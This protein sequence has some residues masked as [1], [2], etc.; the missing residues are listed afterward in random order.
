[1]RR[2]AIVG[3][4]V[5]GALACAR[6]QEKAPPPAT[7][8][9]AAAT[10][11]PGGQAA[12]KPSPATA[13]SPAPGQ[14]ELAGQWEGRYDAKKATITLPAK[15]KE[16]GTDDG[17]SAVGAGTV[18]LAVLA[19]GDVRGKLSGALGAGTITGKLDGAM[20]RASVQP[21]DPYAARAMSG[22]F[23]GEQKGDV[24][25]CE[26]HVAGPDGT[27]IRESVVELRRKK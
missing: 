11:K 19:T 27:V 5:L 25:A 10:P 16:F 15:V 4:L 21:E 14:S 3:V 24:I 17:K 2:I 22:V 8:E 9:A 6:D 18:D 13:P 1:V 12:E 26:L 23:I 20:I 7:T